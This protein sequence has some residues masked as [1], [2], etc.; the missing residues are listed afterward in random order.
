MLDLFGVLIGRLLISPLLLLIVTLI[1][2]DSRGP[3]FYKQVRLGAEGN[4][5]YCWKFRTMHA[6]ADRLLTELLQSDPKLRTEWEKDHKLRDDPRITRTGRSLRKI[7]L[8]ELP[9]L[10]NA[11]RGEMSVVGPRLVLSEEVSKYGEVYVLY[12]RM[13]PDIT[14]LWQVSGRNDTGYEERLGIVA[15]YVR[16]LSIWLDL[17]ILARTALY[18]LLS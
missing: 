1:T 14:G 10:W 8:D 3:V 13:R 4:Y 9:Q 12:Q 6:E 5:F 16:N 11:L 7:S 17:I 2:L 18:R 15:Y